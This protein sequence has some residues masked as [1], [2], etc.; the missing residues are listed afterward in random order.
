[1]FLTAHARVLDHLGRELEEATEL[2]L[3][4][5]EVLLY[6]REAPDGRLRM[7]ELADSLLLSRSAVTRFV[8]RMADAGLVQRTVCDSDRRG[9]FVEATARGRD[10]FRSAAPIHLEGI[11]AHFT[12]FLSDDEAA[13]VADVMARIADAARPGSASKRLVG[14]TSAGADQA[15]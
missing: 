6:L 14:S 3:T 10:L 5:Y 7:H 12:G 9:T 13:V 11:A 4:W 1:M 8:D 15:S 2:P